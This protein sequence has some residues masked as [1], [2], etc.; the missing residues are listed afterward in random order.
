VLLSETTSALVR[1]ELPQGV[2]L[3]DLGRHLLKDIHRP[4]RIS[5]LV[6]EDCR[7]SLLTLQNYRG[8]PANAR[9]R[10]PTGVFGF[11]EADA[12]STSSRLIDAWNAPSA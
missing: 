9:W 10:L 1:D 2:T 4:E 11:Q 3:L 12:S 8:R 6:I 7:N 5:Q